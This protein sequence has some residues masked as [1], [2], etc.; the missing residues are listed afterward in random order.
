[1]RTT[2]ELR[3]DQRSA[4]M[5]LA[6]R[7][8][9]K[10]FSGVLEEAVDAYLDIANEQASKAKRIIDL[11]GTVPPEDAD[12]LILATKEIRGSWRS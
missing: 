6:A 5:A 4:L 1:M 7:R 2:V 11:A 3:D 12:A 9:E 10:G 8:G